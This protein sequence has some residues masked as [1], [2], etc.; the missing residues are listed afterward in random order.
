MLWQRTSAPIAYAVCL[1]RPV[2]AQTLREMQSNSFLYAPVILTRL[3]SVYY[4]LHCTSFTFVINMVD[5]FKLL[6]TTTALA[7]LGAAH[8]VARQV[9]TVSDASSTTV[10]TTVIPSFTDSTTASA[11]SSVKV[12]DLSHLKEDCT[13]G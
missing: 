6:I 12:A 11:T 7:V 10:E 3:T 4:T 8:P 9:S 13:I 1:L 5:T 2:S